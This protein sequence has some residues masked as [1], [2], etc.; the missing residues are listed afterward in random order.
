[1]ESDQIK[2]AEELLDTFDASIKRLV[3]PTT[4]LIAAAFLSRGL[5]NPDSNRFMIIS[6]VTILC[7]FSIGYF[8]FA[9]GLVAKKIEF[10]VKH[11][12]GSLVGGTIYTIMYII[13]F[14]VAITLG[15]NKVAGA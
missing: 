9:V 14:L 7:L 2:N 10:I 13:V 5:D 1:M 6:L 8:V 11:K 15:L 3:T 4:F 12:A